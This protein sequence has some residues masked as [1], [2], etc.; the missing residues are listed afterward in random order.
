MMRL[1][2]LAVA[3]AH[4]VHGTTASSPA[5]LDAIA[6]LLASNNNNPPPSL[7]PTREAPT[8]STTNIHVDK[9]NV[10]TGTLD[11][12]TYDDSDAPPGHARIVAD[13]PNGQV[14]H[15]VR[16]PLNSLRHLGIINVT[17]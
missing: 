15:K 8:T 17:D 1:V 6:A 16:H 7:P 9:Q 2:W 13:A 4:V 12:G 3:S 11:D 10:G 14:W 5:V